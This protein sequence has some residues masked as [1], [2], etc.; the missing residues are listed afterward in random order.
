NVDLIT[1]IP[2]SQHTPDTAKMLSNRFQ[3]KEH[4]VIV[5]IGGEKVTVQIEFSRARVTKEGAT[6]LF[7]MIDGEQDMYKE[8]Q[9][10]YQEKLKGIEVT[11]EYF[12]NKKILHV[13]I[14]D[15]TTEYIY[16]INQK[17][18]LGN[19]TGERQGIGHALEKACKLLNKKRDT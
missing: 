17:P 18:V 11:G 8:F 3:E 7:A 13:D 19:C 14:G 4:V 9:N 5:Y 2:A 6:S 16:T 12:T 1:A 15:G 10:L